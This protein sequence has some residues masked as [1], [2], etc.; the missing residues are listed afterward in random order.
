[1]VI[2]YLNK[3]KAIYKIVIN[4]MKI[5]YIKEI[6]DSKVYDVAEKTPIS[7]LNKISTKY[8][9][10]IFLKREDLQ[11]IFSFKCRGAYNKISNLNADQISKGIIAASAG[12]H[13]QGVALSA[14]K[15]NINALIVMPTTT[16]S[17]KIES[18]K[19]FGVKV[20]LYGDSFDEAYEH[21]LEISKKDERIFIHP[22]DDPLVIAGQ[23]TIAK[24]IVEQTKVTPDIF[25]IPVGGG[26]L[27]S[28]MSLYLKKHY[29]DSKI[30][31]VESE[32]APTLYTALKNGM[33]TKLDQVGL[34]VDGCAVKRIGEETFKISK[35]Y[36]EDV[37]LVSID[38]TCAAI[39]DI[40]ED[41]RVMS[42]PAGALSVAGMKKFIK[43]N[44]IKDKN[45]FAVNSGA[46]LNFDRL[47]HVTERAE[48]GEGK[49]VLLSVKIPEKC[50]SFRSFCEVIGR[51]SVSEFNYRYANDSSANVFV[52]IKTDNIRKDKENIFNDLDINNYNYIDL[53][54]DEVAKL[55][56][57]YMVGGKPNSAI[58]EK[59]IRFE[60]PEKPGALLNFLNKMQKDWDITLF[61]YR[62][63][64]SAFGRVLVGI[65]I[66]NYSAK[67]LDRFLIELGY[68]Y[69]DETLNQ[70]YSSFLK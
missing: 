36:V 41:T 51:R 50:G 38:E 24:E 47:R 14:S 57:R 21:A 43:N 18:V 37:I 11:P 16:P 48:I 54:K 39:K 35:Q 30:Y 64:G 55:H 61:H 25:F 15:L 60:F 53:T 6:D 59:L 28:G 31:G 3:Y 56:L 67:D 22:F 5:N 70:G 45:I 34:F 52:G 33:P 9:N 49:E 1:M 44:D 20:L 26:G 4:Y 8:S 40:Y 69:T 58:N 66:G 19:K 7:L 27:I 13:A 23:G 29:P 2:L 12:N 68:K 10:T 17:I 63:H 32:D 42:E 65:D 62:N 46:N